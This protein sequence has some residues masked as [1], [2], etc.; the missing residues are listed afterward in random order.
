MTNET[1]YEVLGDIEE[2]HIREA[3]AY[4]RAKKPEWKK[5][6]PFAACFALAAVLGL[7]ALQGGWFSG[8]DI[9]KLDNGIIITFI[10]CDGVGGALSPDYDA[11][12]REL[13]AEEAGTLFGGLP[14]TASAV[15]NAADG[16]LVGFDGKIE[17]MKM[18]VSTTGQPLLDT[19]IVGSEK[20]TE[21]GGVPVTA[22]YFLT[23]AN[24]RGE[25]TA[26]YFASFTLGSSSFYVESAGARAESD[27]LKNDLAA[28]VEKLIASGALDID[29]FRHFS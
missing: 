15:F 29:Q 20:K 27:I 11:V 26:I 13:T 12:S 22:G 4:H 7:G 24:S 17:D 3:R 9:A 5:W 19:A 10:K 1:L 8:R 14:V 25:Q 28:V 18:L 23:D 2:K 16:E 6:A 21:V